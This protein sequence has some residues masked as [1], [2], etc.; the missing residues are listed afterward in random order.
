MVRSEEEQEAKCFCQIIER[1]KNLLSSEII[2][3]FYILRNFV[4][5][6]ILARTFAQ[7]INFLPSQNI[8][9]AVYTGTKSSRFYLGRWNPYHSLSIINKFLSVSTHPLGNRA[10]LTFRGARGILLERGPLTPPP[11][12]ILDPEFSKI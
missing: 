8:S 12:G 3:G 6:F 2:C 4:Q 9:L 10:G 11:N 1:F 5:I 7:K